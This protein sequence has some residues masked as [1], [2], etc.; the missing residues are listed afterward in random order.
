MAI[1]INIYAFYRASI[2]NMKRK[3]SLKNA[4]K[5]RFSTKKR[6]F[7]KERV[8]GVLLVFL[9]LIASNQ[10]KAS[11]WDADAGVISNLANLLKAAN[12]QLEEMRHMVSVTDQL[13]ELER[14]K[15]V[16]DAI[17][18][19]KDTQEVFDESDSLIRNIEDWEADPWGTKP[20]ERDLN[21]YSRRA[22]SAENKNDYEAAKI[23]TDMIVSLDRRNYLGKKT[24]G[25]EKIAEENPEAA[26]TQAG[27]LNAELL[28]EINTREQQRFEEEEKI[29]A[30]TPS[31]EGAL[32]GMTEFGKSIQ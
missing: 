14:N 9:V 6:V 26:D 2:G 4:M 10:V 12:N 20:I 21:Y 7:I 25:L 32:K 30:T 13:E 1:N 29:K 3:C 17:N 18:I 11:V 22:D 31:L 16:S 19:A 27:V 24:E 28:N 23:W 15:I 8:G 5:D